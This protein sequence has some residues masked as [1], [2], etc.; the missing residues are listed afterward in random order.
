MFIFLVLLKLTGK[1]GNYDGRT[2]TIISPD[3]K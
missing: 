1:V 3:T 2:K